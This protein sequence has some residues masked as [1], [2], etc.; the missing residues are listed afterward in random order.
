MLTQMS[1]PVSAMR[2]TWSRFHHLKR[3]FILKHAHRDQKSAPCPCLATRERRAVCRRAAWPRT[4]LM[5][6]M[7]LLLLLLQTHAVH[8]S[9]SLPTLYILLSPATSMEL[10]GQGAS[11]RLYGMP[12]CLPP[13]LPSIVC[14]MPPCG[15]FVRAIVQPNINITPEVHKSI[16]NIIPRLDP[17]ANPRASLHSLYSV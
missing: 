8:T 15:A 17:W 10:Q 11:A 16:I 14:N 12:P 7:L 3:I 13:C 4:T 5:P 6:M 1:V 9:F 2:K